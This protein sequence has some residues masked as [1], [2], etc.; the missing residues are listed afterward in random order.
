MATKIIKNMDSVDH[1]YAG[2][3]VVAGGQYQ[4]QS[5]EEGRWAS[6]SSLL[7]DIGSGKA[8]VNNGT[9]DITSVNLAI[10]YL[11]DLPLTDGDGYQITRT[12]A[13]NNTDGYYFRGKGVAGSITA[14]TT[15][16]LDY[17]LTSERWI[18]GCHLILRNHAW[19]DSLLFQVV[20]VDN[21]LGY[22]AGAVLNEF[23]STWQ[24]TEDKQDQGIFKIEYPAKILNGLYIR[25]RY[26]STGAANVGVKC[27]YFLHM[28]T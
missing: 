7:S 10:N 3:T 13:F 27:N 8:I 2:Q 14:G 22:G 12:R 26:T 18:N 11:K 5:Q 28:K 4:I 19:D 1:I 24:I 25:I 16:N 17:K 20:D 23:A 21:V 6:D 9:A 15:G